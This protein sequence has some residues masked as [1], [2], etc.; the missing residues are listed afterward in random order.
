M[1]PLEILLSRREGGKGCPH[2]LLDRVAS[3]P[4]ATINITK[5]RN[6]PLRASYSTVFDWGTNNQKDK[7]MYTLQVTTTTWSAVCFKLVG[8]KKPKVPACQ[9]LNN[10]ELICNHTEIIPFSYS[11]VKLPPGW[12][13]LRR[14]WAYSY[15]PANSTWGPCTLGRLIMVLPSL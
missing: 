6:F 8:C 3:G 5:L 11:Y 10:E 7:S 14:L 4:Q 12:F 13:F 1:F 9:N 2:H 15:L